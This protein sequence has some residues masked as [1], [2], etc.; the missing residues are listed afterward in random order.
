VAERLAVLGATLVDGLSSATT[1]RSSS[2][3][4]LMLPRPRGAAVWA[5]AATYGG[6]L[7]AGDRIGLDLQVGAGAALCLGTQ[8]TTKVFR[9]PGA[10]AEQHL[11]AGVADGGLL[12]ILPEPLSP[13]AGSRYRQRTRLRLAPGASLA[14]LDTVSAGRMARDERWQLASY[15]ARLDLE[16]D[17]RLVL[18]DTL[19][20]GADAPARL[21][22]QAAVAS[23]LLVGPRAAE[24]AQAGRALAE[25]HR[26]GEDGL[27][28]AA[29]P[30]A[31]GILLRLAALD[32][33]VL[34][35]RIRSVIAPLAEPLDG[36]PWRR[37]ASVEIACT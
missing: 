6:G 20:L 35:S 24:A 25:L 2:D 33:E 18:R 11:Q 26:P 4:K 27:L 32:L 12:A 3:L 37:L 16:L 5:C 1:W 17:G 30:V 13:F 22:A 36:D 15:D 8:S 21:G 29:S 19:R 14:W 28:I 7:V 34:A 23:L 31:D 9:S 10:V